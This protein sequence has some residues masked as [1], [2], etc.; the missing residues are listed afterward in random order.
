MAW[1]AIHFASILWVY[2]RRSFQYRCCLS[3][4][5]LAKIYVCFIPYKGSSLFHSQ[6]L[7][8]FRPLKHCIRARF[9][10][11]MYISAAW[12]NMPM[13]GENV[14][15]TYFDSSNWQSIPGI[16][17]KIII[18]YSIILHT[19]PYIAKQYLYMLLKMSPICTIFY[20]SEHLSFMNSRIFTVVYSTHQNF[21]SDEK[22]VYRLIFS[23]EK[24]QFDKRYLKQICCLRFVILCKRNLRVSNRVKYF[25][26]ASSV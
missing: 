6:D 24:Q 22:N 15:P 4:E 17:F 7:T 3:R 20:L 21:E 23:N 16:N 1:E 14:M 26:V 10:V 25:E 2:L 8:S 13:W 12:W 19:K 5:N 9:A 18:M 11:Y